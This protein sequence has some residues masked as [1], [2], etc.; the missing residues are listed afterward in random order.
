[1]RLALALALW[2]TVAL[3][4]TSHC[5]E[6]AN[7]DSVP[8]VRSAVGK[9][10]ARLVAEAIKGMPLKNWHPKK[11]MALS[12]VCRIELPP[13]EGWADV[14][15][16]LLYLDAANFFFCQ[17]YGG[18]PVWMIDSNATC[19]FDI[20]ACKY[21]LYPLRG[22]IGGSI[23]VDTGI[24]FSQ[25]RGD[26]KETLKLNIDLTKFVEWE[27]S[28]QAAVRVGT[29]NRYL[30]SLV[31][32]QDGVGRSSSILVDRAYGF[33]IR[34]LTARL[35]GKGI[36]RMRMT[37]TMS[38]VARSTV[39]RKRFISA[40]ILE[41]AG[42]RY[43]VMGPSAASTATVLQPNWMESK[44]KRRKLLSALEKINK[45]CDWRHIWNTS[46]ETSLPIDDGARKAKARAKAKAKVEV[47]SDASVRP[48]TPSQ[49]NE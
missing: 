34:R 29:Q 17:R 31:G 36:E 45:R 47:K 1:M 46:P 43:D 4:T 21:K 14:E 41:S 27:T 26:A 42:L 49:A 15:G 37:L 33:P 35:E 32:Q 13:E 11:D 38:A 20:D 39:Y 9:N 2:V 12:A 48:S 30:L 40:K 19:Y 8:I 28:P 5:G 22:P 10:A 25:K 24:R 6:A 18:V 23:S 44:A 3:N 7:A 16:S